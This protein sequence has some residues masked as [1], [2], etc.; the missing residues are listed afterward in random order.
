[1]AR[2]DHANARTLE[3]DLVADIARFELDPLGYVMYAFP[4]GEP[5]TELAD[6]KGPRKWQRTVLERI[7]KKLR[8]MAGK[9]A[10]VARRAKLAAKRLAKAFGEVIREAVCS[11][12]GVGKGALAAMLAMWALSTHEDTKIVVTANTQTQLATKTMPEV[13]KWHRLSINSHWFVFTAT[14]LYSADETH[15]K[16]WRLDAIPWSEHNTE[17]FAGLHNQGKR[18]IVIYDEASAIAD[19][20]WEVTEGALTDEATQIIWLTLGNGTRATGQFRECFRKFRHRWE[21]THVD[22]RDVEGTNKT[23]LDQ[24]VSDYGVDSDFVKVRVRGMFPAQSAKQFISE[25]DVDA[26]YGRQLRLEQYNFAPKILA[27]EPAWTGDDPF[28]IGLRQGLKFNVLRSV[29]KNDNDLVMGSL[30]AA[31]EDEHQADAVFIDGG[32]GTGIVSY[33]RTIGRNWIIVWFG[34]ESTDPGCKNKRAEMWKNTR[35]WLKEGG[36]IEPR[37]QLKDDLIGP[38]TVPDTKDGKL[39]L[40]PKEAMK[41]RGLPSPNEGDCLALTFAHPVAVKKHESERPRRGQ[42]QHEYN[43]LEGVGA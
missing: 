13:A 3:D 20:V 28:V 24:W 26:A 37:Q 31:L 33:G 2:A 40:E 21:C 16:T 30:V 23:L 19:K 42:T 14:S 43:P 11:G 22:S 8:A 6:V 15:S 38:E 18:I 1:M 25:A 35:D 32:F 5:G 36:S 29:P 41:L 12:H 17:A 27:V 34:G 10:S 9:G 4:W 7:G 39:L